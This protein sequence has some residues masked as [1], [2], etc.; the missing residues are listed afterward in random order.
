MKQNHSPRQYASYEVLIFELD[1][2]LQGPIT[3]FITKWQ[4][5]PSR[6]LS[7]SEVN[8][9]KWYIMSTHILWPNDI[10]SWPWPLTCNVKWAR[11]P[12]SPSLLTSHNYA[13]TNEEL[14]CGNFSSIRSK[15]AARRP[16]LSQNYC[17][18][19]HNPQ[20][21]AP[22]NFVFI[23]NIMAHSNTHP[24]DY[25]SLTLT[26]TFKVKYPF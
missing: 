14:N 17:K 20:N 6:C 7:R 10:S 19:P 5:W 11:D 21:I 8:E 24:M 13:P 12:W 22:S 25:W 16:F 3:N 9:T 23:T 4:I 1:L 15:M 18:L 2:D 26:F